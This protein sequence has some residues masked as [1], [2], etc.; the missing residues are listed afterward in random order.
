MKRRQFL[1]LLIAA[2]M[3]S[4]AKCHRIVGNLLPRPFTLAKKLSRYPGKIKSWT[5]KEFQT[6]G[7][8]KG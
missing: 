1:S 7:R 2:S 8:W 5:Q 3:V 6:I 4:L